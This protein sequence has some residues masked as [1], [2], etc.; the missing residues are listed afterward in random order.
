MQTY[1]SLS[2]DL[3]VEAFLL[4]PCASAID[5]LVQE[6]QSR[7]Q[8]SLSTSVLA[9]KVGQNALPQKV[10]LFLFDKCCTLHTD[11]RLLRGY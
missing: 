9:R 2:R 10:S 1:K 11:L 8:V 4:V 3:V 6:F 5:F 7:V